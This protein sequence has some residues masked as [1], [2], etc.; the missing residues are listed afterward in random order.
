VKRFALLLWVA[1][2]VSFDEIEDYPCPEGGTTLTYQN[3]GQPL[4]DRWCNEC[5]NALLEDR[6]QAPED[7]VFDSPLAVREWKERIFIRAALGNDSMPPGANGPSGADRQRL[8]EWL[9]CGAP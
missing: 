5:H 2:C 4:L 7:V 1:S 6:Q 9:A 3:F 8:A